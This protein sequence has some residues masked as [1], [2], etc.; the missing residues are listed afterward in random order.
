[1]NKKY[2]SNQFSILM[3]PVCA[4]CVLF[5]IFKKWQLPSSIKSVPKHLNSSV[6]ILYRVCVY[7]GIY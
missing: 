2:N 1:M 7:T 6:Y 5:M 3:C 4:V